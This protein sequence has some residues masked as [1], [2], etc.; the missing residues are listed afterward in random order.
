[1]RRNERTVLMRKEQAAICH[2]TVL[3]TRPSLKG[4][5]KEKTKTDTPIDKKIDK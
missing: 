3:Q 1:M 2:S 5:D 4:R